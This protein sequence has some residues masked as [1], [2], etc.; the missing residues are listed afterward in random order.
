[1][2]GLA[3]HDES[4]QRHHALLD[5]SESPGLDIAALAD[6][7]QANAQLLK[8]AMSLQ[9]ACGD[10]EIRESEFSRYV[11]TTSGLAAWQPAGLCPGASRQS[12]TLVT[13][14]PLQFLYLISWH[15]W[16]ARSGTQLGGIRARAWSRKSLARTWSG[17]DTGFRKR[18][19]ST[20]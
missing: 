4:R 17:L 2:L 20:N 1:V 3:A 5:F 13:R 11:G 15:Y 9:R 6:G 16:R 19:C 12:R 10:A 18:S 7:E 8:L 14:L